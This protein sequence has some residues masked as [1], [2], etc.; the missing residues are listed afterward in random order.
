ML[1][2]CPGPTYYS[3]RKDQKP[4]NVLKKHPFTL[5]YLIVLPYGEVGPQLFYQ[6]YLPISVP[7]SVKKF[8]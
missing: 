7:F 3:K 5:F 4:R 6:N 2:L 1:T 8:L